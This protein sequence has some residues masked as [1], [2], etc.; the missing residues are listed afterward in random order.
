MKNITTI[1][2]ILLSVSALSGCGHLAS[3]KPSYCYQLVDEPG[4]MIIITPQ[5]EEVS[6]VDGSS[7]FFD[8]VAVSDK[9]GE[10]KTVGEIREGSFY[11]GDGSRW[12][13]NE[14][15]AVGFGGLIEGMTATSTQCP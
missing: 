13:F 11:Y 8:T 12:E 6:G 7:I 10:Q 2:G 1:V 4:T 5:G 15:E 9:E 14:Q 3:K